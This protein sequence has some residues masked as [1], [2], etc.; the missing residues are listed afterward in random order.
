MNIEIDGRRFN[1]IIKYKKVKYTNLKIRQNDLIITSF[2][3]ISE[4]EALN[5]INKNINAIKKLIKKVPENPIK[6]DE[7]LLFGKVYK[8]NISDCP[9]SINDTVINVAKIDEIY[10]YAFKKVFEQF[11]QIQKLYFYDTP[12]KLIFKKMK[13]RWG[14]CYLKKATIALTIPIIHLPTDV[15][16]YVIIHEFCHFKYPNHSKDFYN[17][18]AKYCPNYKII[19]KKLK[20]FAYVI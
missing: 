17:Y 12:S 18:V 2:K 13:T 7:F 9:L 3:Y 5:F 6:D 20:S 10:N 8:L 4:E 14:V 19:I 16:E 15:I 1:L 11:N